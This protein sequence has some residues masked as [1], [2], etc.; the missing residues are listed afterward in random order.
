MNN[1]FNQFGMPI[2][3]LP[4]SGINPFGAN[5]NTPYM[6]PTKPMEYDSV[7][8]SN[9]QQLKPSFWDQ[10][11]M[12][13]SQYGTKIFGW[14]ATIL[15]GLGAFALGKKFINLDVPYGKNAPKPSDDA[16]LMVKAK[17]HLCT[18]LS[19]TVGV[20]KP[21]E[22]PAKTEEDGEADEKNINTIVNNLETLISG[23]TPDI[24]T[25]KSTID[26]L[27]NSLNG[28]K[29]S[30][31]L[32]KKIEKLN[33]TV[34]KTT[35]LNDTIT[36]HIKQDLE[37]IKTLLQPTPTVPVTSEIKPSKALEDI[38]TQCI[39][40]FQYPT[41]REKCQYNSNIRNL[42]GNESVKLR[43][44]VNLKECNP[45]NKN[46]IQK[47]T[48]IGINNTDA[49][50]ILRYSYLTTSTTNN[51]TTINPIT[52]I[53]NVVL[54]AK[55]SVG[56]TAT[57]KDS[58]K[59]NAI[60]NALKIFYDI[61]TKVNNKNT[62]QHLVANINTLL[63]ENTDSTNSTNAFILIRYI[64]E[65]CK[66]LGIID[67]QTQIA[68]VKTAANAQTVMLTDPTKVQKDTI[69]AVNVTK[70]D[71]TTSPKK[72]EYLIKLSDIA[73]NA[74]DTDARNTAN[75]QTVMLTDHK[76]VQKDTI[77][78]VD[79]TKLDATTKTNYL[80]KLPDIAK[81]AIDTDARNTANAQTVMLTDHK[82]VQK[83]TIN[84]VDVTKLDATTKANY[85]TKLSN[86]AKN[87]SVK[88]DVKN[89]AVNAKVNILNNIEETEYDKT[90]TSAADL[91][92]YLLS[93][94]E[95]KSL[96]TATKA[97]YVKKLSNI[98]EKSKIDTVKTAAVEA[99]VNIFK[100]LEETEYDKTFTSAADL[101]NYLLSDVELKSLNTATKAEYVKKLSNIATKTTEL[102]VKTTVFNALINQKDVKKQMINKNQLN[103]TYKTLP[104][105][106]TF[107]L[108]KLSMPPAD[109]S[110]YSK[111]TFILNGTQ[112]YFKNHTK[113]YFKVT[114]FMIKT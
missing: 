54:L 91:K 37:E 16:S 113:Q 105:Q 47:A 24:N 3:N 83:D 28:L 45:I 62:F 108:E 49:L 10:T 7:S 90:F 80:A 61:A 81:N 67:I 95:L 53:D 26:S 36:N 110:A 55:N 23:P 74:I 22:A 11:K 17:Y 114:K 82:K 88:A 32:V 5:G 99:K 15:G 44:F 77:N 38:K 92:N 79:V 39:H 31:D 85:L 4:M 112:I 111:N 73:T 107:T 6:A 65:Q 13:F 51:I 43:D 104:L 34:N 68:D 8:F 96:N 94:V 60:G 46:T 35:S 9:R 20:M 103:I 57:F 86:I 50:E 56:N 102:E 18:F 41:Y 42:K 58:D 25:L 93:D 40:I 89:A 12:F 52:L 106:Y 70:L 63:E 14:G 66:T 97:E 101:K 75:A 33:D 19:D 78:A 69:N 109:F 100:N 72:S 27:R 98:A 48:R 30:T 1:N 21:Y 76:K 64:E 71:E 59:N 84:A 2:N 87:T 29:S